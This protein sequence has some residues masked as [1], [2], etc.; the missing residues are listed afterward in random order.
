LNRRR[1]RANAKGLV[2]SARAVD[3]EDAR[4]LG[5]VNHVVEEDELMAKTEELAADFAEAPAFAL[6]LAK[7]LFHAAV[8]PSLDSYLEIE[9]LVQ[10]QL[11]MT[12]DNAEGVAAF[13][14][15][16]KPKFIGR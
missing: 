9:S 6:G 4:A 1:G 5:L 16:R 13:R 8:G 12:A 11:H 10:P 14:E 3:G 2:C 15:K 7:K